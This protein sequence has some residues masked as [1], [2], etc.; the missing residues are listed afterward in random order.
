MPFDEREVTYDT[1][2]KSGGNHPG[3]QHGDVPH[4]F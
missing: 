3:K 2:K 1:G 4:F